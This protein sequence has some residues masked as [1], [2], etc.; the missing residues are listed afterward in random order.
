M[1]QPD[2]ARGKIPGV[3][4]RL[5]NLLAAVSSVLCAA[6]VVLWV[7]SSWVCDFVEHS[8]V[9]SDH[10]YER[11]F[12]SSDQGSLWLRRDVLTYDQISVSGA[13]REQR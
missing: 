1:I 7:R 5:F 6:T 2:V 8:E 9:K 4:R 12:L 10:V 11:S 3:K 13:Y